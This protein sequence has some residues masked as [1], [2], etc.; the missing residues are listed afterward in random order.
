MKRQYRCFQNTESSKVVTPNPRRKPSQASRGVW[1]LSFNLD[2][3]TT[4]DIRTEGT[5]NQVRGACILNEST[6]TSARSAPAPAV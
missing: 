4:P 3:K 2:D 1:E 6:S 5:K